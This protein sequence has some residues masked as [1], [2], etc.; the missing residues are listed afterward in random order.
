M[1]YKNKGKVPNHAITL[2]ISHSTLISSVDYHLSCFKSL[3]CI[4]IFA[5]STEGRNSSFSG[6]IMCLKNNK[7]R[8]VHSIVSKLRV[9]V[10][11]SEQ[12]QLPLHLIYQVDKLSDIT[13]CVVMQ[14]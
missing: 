12:T 8:S 2:I 9:K 1:G 5:H 14:E 4:H 11:N 10:V 6:G 13:K 7:N 3:I